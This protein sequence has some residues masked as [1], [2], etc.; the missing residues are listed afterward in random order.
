M[1][2]VSMAEIKA[3]YTDEK[4]ALDRR[5]LLT[6]FVFRKISWYP[7]WLLLKL[8][9]SAN[10]A[11]ALGLIAG[12]IG[13]LFFTFGSYTSTVIGAILVYCYVILDH[14]D[15]NIARYNDSVSETGEFVEHLCGFVVGIVA[16]ASIGI[17]LFHHP[18]S[19]LNS[20]ANY[21]FNVDVASWVYLVLG[22][23]TALAIAMPAFFT[24]Y[25]EGKKFPLAVRTVTR[26]KGIAGR[27][28]SVLHRIY[29]FIVWHR[30]TFILLGAV[31]KFLSIVLFIFAVVY[32]CSFVA[33]LVGKY[34][35][36]KTVEV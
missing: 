9:F 32:S 28:S 21:L 6:Y 2:K 34:M 17:G 19:V 8:G 4:R 11:S 33:G 31:F 7:T 1:P 10:E 23:L 16:F 3:K 20:I 22:G 25:L 27:C 26:S 30:M 14:V 24:H 15:G 5:G 35:I 29:T 13:C 36:K 12:L 18:D